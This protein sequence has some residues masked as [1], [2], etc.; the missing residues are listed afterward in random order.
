VAQ[1]QILERFVKSQILLP[2]EAREKIDMPTRS[3][4]KGGTPLELS[5]RQGIDARANA[6]QNRQRDSERTNNNSDSVATTTGRNA[7]GEG[8]KV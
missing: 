5:A 8:R 1:S 6:S 7:Q 4:G 3:D 2:D